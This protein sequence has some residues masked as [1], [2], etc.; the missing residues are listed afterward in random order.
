[1]DKQRIGQMLAQLTL[2]ASF[3]LYVKSLWT[4]WVEDTVCL[5]E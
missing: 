3:T 4:Q 5:C 2:N 1:M